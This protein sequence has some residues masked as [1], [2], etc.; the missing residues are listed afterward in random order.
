MVE[1]PQ[2]PSRCAWPTPRGRHRCPR[3][4]A[5]RSCAAGGAANVPPPVRH[6][7]ACTADLELLDQ[8]V[9]EQVLA[10]LQ[11]GALELSLAAAE[12]VLRE[13]QRLDENWRQRLE[14]ARY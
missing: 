13:R 6:F 4:R 2:C 5:A 7:G 9:T 8:L 12:D 3:G 11:P 1:L 14:R 10:A